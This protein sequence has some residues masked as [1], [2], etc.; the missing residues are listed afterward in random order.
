MGELEKKAP[1]ETLGENSVDNKTVDWHQQRI[2]SL[3]EQSLEIVKILNDCEKSLISE[4]DPQIKNKLEQQITHYKERLNTCQQE[5]ESIQGQQSLQ[6][7]I[8]NTV[9]EV[10][11]EDLDFV[12]TALLNLQIPALSSSADFSLTA[13][14]RKM[15][16]NELTQSVQGMLTGGLAQAR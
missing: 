7:V 4:G 16:K 3:K 14:P 1:A 5:V 12:I 13:P 15:S 9:P 2:Q 10:T 8:T 6:R 11:F